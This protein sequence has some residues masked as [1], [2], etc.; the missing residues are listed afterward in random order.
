MYEIGEK[1]V[2]VKTHSQGVVKEGD[3]KTLNDFKK[4]CCGD[5]VFNV[6]IKSSYKIGE[7]LMCP[8]CNKPKISDGIWWIYAKLFRPI[9]DLY[10]E[11]IKELTE[12][13][14]E[15]VTF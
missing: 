2:C 8:R 3:I 10:N 1:V 7:Y 5:L 13:L 15:P 6:G 12:A 4:G 9:D 11:E 14:N